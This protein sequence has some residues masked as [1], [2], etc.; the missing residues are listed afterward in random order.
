MFTILMTFLS[1][2]QQWAQI[3]LPP[4]D[5]A[6]ATSVQEGTG[7]EGLGNPFVLHTERR[8][9]D[10]LVSRL[11][12]AK[13][14]NRHSTTDVFFCYPVS[15]RMVLRMWLTS[16]APLPETQG[17]QNS[18]VRRQDLGPGS[19]QGETAVARETTGTEGLFPGF[20]AQPPIPIH[21]RPCYFPSGVM[22][23]GPKLQG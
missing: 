19:H 2:P 8:K 16:G 4:P 12:P 11:M 22:E 9:V 6:P 15:F 14:K 7:T 21:P 13:R 5:T 18:P 17:C 3:K 23:R 20:S 1:A 10:S